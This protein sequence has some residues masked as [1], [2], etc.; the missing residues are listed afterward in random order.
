MG[1]NC[2]TRLG[3]DQLAFQAAAYRAYSRLLSL[4]GDV[5]GAKAFEAAAA[6]V[7]RFIEGHFWDDTNSRFNELLLTDGRY[8]TGGDMRVYVL[9]NAAATSPD[10]IGKT[11]QSFTGAGSVNIELGSHYPEVFYRYG[12]HGPAYRK[13][14]EISDP[15]TPRREYPEVSF[16]VVGAMVGG[17]MGIEPSETEGRIATLSR[18]TDP[19]LWA[20]I[21]HLPVHGNVIDVR[22]KGRIETVLTNRSGKAITWIPRF[23]GAAGRIE[24]DGKAIEARAGRDDAGESLIWTEAAVA[25]GESKTAC[26]IAP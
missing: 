26:R 1:A 3:I 24:V 21:G 14:L 8:T 19:V 12:A 9:Y 5:Q 10:K 16:A 23:Y 20:E 2:K 15:K 22:H 4:R 17:L 7:E 6:E 25:P 11:L 13:L 18:L